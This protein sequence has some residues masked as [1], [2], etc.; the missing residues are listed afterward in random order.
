LGLPVESKIH[1]LFEFKTGPWGGGNQFLK[2]LWKQLNERGIA[3][4]T[5]GAA[6]IVL[7]NSHHKLSEL[8]ALRRRHPEKTIVHRV[9]GPIHLIRNRDREVDQVLYRVNRG[10]AEGTIFQSDWSR[11]ANLDAG[12]TPRGPSTVIFNAPDPSLFHPAPEE[13]ASPPE[14]LRLIATSWSPNPRKGFD[15]YSWLDDNLDFDRFEMTFVGN[16]P[17]EFRHIRKLEPL[18][19]EELADE[20]RRHHVFVTGSR[21]DPCSNSLLEALHCGLPALARRDGGHPELIGEAGET[22]V[23]L[24]E[25]IEKLQLVAESY[26]DYRRRIRVPSIGEVAE[27]YV[28]FMEA[29]HRERDR[30]AVAGARNLLALRAT[31]MALDHPAAKRLLAAGSAITGGRFP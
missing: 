30:S 24:P 5:P 25:A 21:V 28:S 16:S 8:A 3:A 22:F 9:D 29:V 17:V 12:M 26:D 31:A 18:A 13:E 23:E 4:E 1:I 2:A 11:R 10:L 27:L 14:R 19:S 15:L 7:A 6:D 20:L